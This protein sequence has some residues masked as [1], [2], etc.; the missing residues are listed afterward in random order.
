MSDTLIDFYAKPAVSI[1]F[2]PTFGQVIIDEF[3]N[4][5]E[6]NCKVDL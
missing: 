3:T 1:L 4:V 6:M 5:R 2:E